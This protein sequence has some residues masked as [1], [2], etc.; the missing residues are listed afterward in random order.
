MHRQSETF[1]E[2]DNFDIT[3]R[4]LIVSV[5]IV[6]IML[7]IGNVISGNV[8]RKS[9]E[10]KQ[11]YNTA[12]SIDSE[13]MFDYGL[14]TNVGNAFCQGKLTALDTVSDSMIRGEWMSIY[15]E[16]EHYN[17]HVRTVT[18]TD[19]KGHTYA[20]IEIYYSWDFYDSETKH[21]NKVSFLGKEFDYDNISFSNRY[22]ETV[23][24]GSR[25]R[26]KFYVKDTQYD[27]TLFTN[28]DNKTINNSQFYPNKDI[29]QAKA[30]LISSAGHRVVIFWVVW[31]VITVV[32]VFVFYVAKNRWLE[33]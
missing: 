20:A 18:R 4:E 7:I 29:E 15:R 3:Y 14:R 12:I 26:F 30:D 22:L 19:G 31:I 23:S 10:D 33:D 8:V 5:A 6:F 16:E 9:L 27:G 21:C 17:Q 32:I 28:I 1:L 25:V 24:S 11:K 13:N 2:F